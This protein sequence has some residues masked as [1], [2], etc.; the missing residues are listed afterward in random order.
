[1]RPYTIKTFA[2][3]LLIVTL[4]TLYHDAVYYIDLH[5]NVDYRAAVDFGE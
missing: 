2:L 5:H 4:L 1:M 3:Y